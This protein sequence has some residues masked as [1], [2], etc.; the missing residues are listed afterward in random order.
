MLVSGRVILGSLAAAVHA[1]WHHG[2]SIDFHSILDSNPLTL[3]AFV[4]PWT[5][6][7]KSLASEWATA[8][9]QLT[10]PLVSIDWTAE[11]S[12]CTAHKV[13][14]Y[15][16]IRLFHVPDESTRYGGPRKAS[17]IV[18][19]VVRASLPAV[20]EVNVKNITDL[21]GIDR[22][23]VVAHLKIDE[24]SMRSKFTRVAEA[25][26]NQFVFGIADDKRL[27]QKEKIEFPSI[28]AYKTDVGD[29]EVLHGAVKRSVIES[30]VLEA[31]KPLIDELTR[32]NELNY[33]SSHELIAYIFVTDAADRASLRRKFHPVA[34]QYKDC[35]NFVTIDGIEYGHIS[36]S[37]GL[38]RGH[39]PGFTVYSAWKDQVFPYPAV[40]GIGADNI[41]EF[42]LEI[43]HGKRAPWNP[44][45]AG[46]GQHDE[47]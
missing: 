13:H 41:E 35:V 37:L 30:F 36:P 27:A 40:K 14:S 26:R 31:G 39:Y 42:L 25:F 11:P 6:P 34:K 8:K 1:Q 44:A 18:S 46:H 7:S 15:P 16:A 43:L 22:V 29:Q 38:H 3:V 28:I 10:Y 21:V 5:A 32:R 20:S 45:G 47:L 19:F 9:F 33:M 17:A 4:A 2:S 12:L 24:G 23:T